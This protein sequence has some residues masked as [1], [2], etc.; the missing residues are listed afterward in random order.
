[1]FQNKR[2][3]L[4]RSASYTLSKE[5]TVNKS[6]IKRQSTADDRS[7]FEQ[8]IHRLAARAGDVPIGWRPVYHKALVALRAIDCPARAHIQLTSPR[9]AD[10]NLD[11]GVTKPDSCIDGILRKLRLRTACTCELCGATGTLR[12]MDRT[13]QVMCAECAAPRLLRFWIS[14]F[15][16]QM[17]GALP[18]GS[19]LVYTYDQV[20]LQL[21]PLIPATA[22]SASG[23]SC[24]GALAVSL[25]LIEM[26][27]FQGR[28]EAVGNSLDLLVAAKDSQ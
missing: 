24:K 6:S 17:A 8:S 18:S 10:L 22:W 25:S 4:D 21:R 20:P 9:M 12:S 7:P 19:R 13:L 28:F 14:S 11:V 27:A 5:K 15:V 3:G 1:M 2:A 26:A 23:E 16:Q